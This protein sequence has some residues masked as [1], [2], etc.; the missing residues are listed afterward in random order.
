MPQAYEEL[1]MY[2]FIHRMTLKPFKKMMLKVNEKFSSHFLSELFKE[3]DTQFKGSIYFK[4]L[5]NYY[6]SNSSDSEMM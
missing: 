4:E 2:D 3:I 5:I 6:L 1:S